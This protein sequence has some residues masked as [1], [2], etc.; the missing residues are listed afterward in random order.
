MPRVIS[1]LLVATV[2]VNAT[3]PRPPTHCIKERQKSSVFGHDSM[4]ATTENPVPV[5]ADMDSNAASKKDMPV[6]RKGS[7][8]QRP[9]ITQTRAVAAIE[10][11]VRGTL[12]TRLM[13]VHPSQ[14]K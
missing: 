9:T 10:V 13:K 1:P 5:H 4:S 11:L 7:D 12:D 6:K 8:P 2:K 3:I 14:A